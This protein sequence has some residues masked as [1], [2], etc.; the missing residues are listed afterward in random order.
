MPPHCQ[1]NFWCQI[2]II[3]LDFGTRTG[4]AGKIFVNDP[5]YLDSLVSHQ[6][7][8]KAMYQLPPADVPVIEHDTFAGAARYFKMFFQDRDYCLINQMKHYKRVEN[9]Q[10]FSKNNIFKMFFNF[11]FSFFFFFALSPAHIVSFQ[12]KKNTFFSSKKPT[13]IEK[14][15]FPSNHI[16]LPRLLVKRETFQQKMP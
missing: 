4:G 15:L 11:S 14:H 2:T 12:L 3:P 9:Q 13:W 8:R 1:P 6:S 5:S 10:V 16:Q 7:L